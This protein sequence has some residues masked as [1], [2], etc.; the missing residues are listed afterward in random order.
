MTF[1]DQHVAPS[2]GDLALGRPLASIRFIR[3]TLRRA[4]L[5]PG[6]DEIN[7]VLAV[8]V[9]VARTILEIIETMFA[10]R[11]SDCDQIRLGIPL[12]RTRRP[13]SVDVLD[14]VPGDIKAR[15]SLVIWERVQQNHL[16]QVLLIHG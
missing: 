4:E 1:L 11:P 2:F 7:A 12:G 9:H 13:L 8:D 6:Q 15:R 10:A 5:A 3:G 16:E 14:P